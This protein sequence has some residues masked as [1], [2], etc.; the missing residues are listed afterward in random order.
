MEGERERERICTYER[1]RENRE[2]VRSTPHSGKFCLMD[3]A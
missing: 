2:Q 1:I 3:E